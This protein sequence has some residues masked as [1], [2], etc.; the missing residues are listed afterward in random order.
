MNTIAGVE[1]FCAGYFSLTYVYIYFGGIVRCDV[2]Q[3]TR[4]CIVQ[5]D[6]NIFIG[7]NAI[8]TEGIGCA[9]MNPA[10]RFIQIFRI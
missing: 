8:A 4:F 6:D 2:N 1:Y 5:N 3:Y 7:E 10:M 9:M